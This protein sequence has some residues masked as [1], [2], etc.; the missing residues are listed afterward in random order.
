MKH[1]R[2]LAAIGMLLVAMA[3]WL[4]LLNWTRSEV[5]I[6]LA[7]LAL[8]MLAYNFLQT[9]TNRFGQHMFIFFL[10]GA[11]LLGIVFAAR[12]A[13][14]YVRFR[15]PVLLVEGKKWSER[16]VYFTP[17]VL[18]GIAT[19]G[20]FTIE[21]TSNPQ[22]CGLCHTMN[23]YYANWQTSRHGKS[24][25]SCAQCHYEPGLTGYARAKV[26]G[27]SELVSQV[28]ATQKYKPE[29]V[30]SDVSC[31]RS[32]CHTVEKLG[33]VKSQK[34]MFDHGIHIGR[35]VAGV[36]LRCT[37]CHSKVGTNIHFAVDEQTCFSCHFSAQHTVS[38][39]CTG[40]HGIPEGKVGERQFQHRLFVRTMDDTQCRRCHASAVQDLSRLVSTQC[41]ACHLEPSADLLKADTTSIHRAHVTDRG[42]K[43]GSCHSS[44]RHGRKGHPPALVADCSSC[45]GTRHSEP[46]LLLAGLGGTGVAHTPDRHIMVG[47]ECVGCHAESGAA[48]EINLLGASRSCRQCHDATYEEFVDQ[49]KN[50]LAMELSSLAA[51][52]QKARARL[53]TVS[54]DDRTRVQGLLQEARRNIELVRKGHGVHN[55]EYAKLLL[56]NAR[57][58][59][60]A[61]LSPRAAR[62]QVS[63]T[64]HP[65]EKNRV[66][67]VRSP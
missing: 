63:K 18:I 1:R 13:R 41:R 11:A 42:I 33:E 22:F 50:D 45:H 19:L 56:S 53:Q 2:N 10:Y 66:I 7:S 17:I 23:N 4:L 58:G 30:V 12:V 57:G 65:E 15:R 34:F 40:C 24:E 9:T 60:E 32:G 51:L 38:P 36:E 20:G 54:E 16:F 52:E 6:Y 31:L 25:V 21:S 3:V 39:S 14:N 37:S 27:V 67:R 26:K 35:E 55:Y 61:A 64:L 59:L 43:C 44:V 46:E 5:F 28:T 47:V 48:G 29:G 62:G 49:W 8:A